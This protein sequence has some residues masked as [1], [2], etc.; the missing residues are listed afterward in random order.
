MF[1]G[2]YDL[3]SITIDENNNYL[4]VI[5]YVIYSKNKSKL[6]FYPLGKENTYYS[7][8]EG[9]EIIGYNS[10]L[11][12]QIETVIFP[13][14]LQKIEENAFYMNTKLQSIIIPASVS[15]IEKNAFAGCRRL[16]KVILL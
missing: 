14:S 5:D 4:T 2:C 11:M 13:S 10:F 7:I 12:S 8:E 3:N 1:D 16:E 9:V 6:I 15:L